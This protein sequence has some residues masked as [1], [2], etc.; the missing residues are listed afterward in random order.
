[1]RYYPE[2]MGHNFVSGL[3]T[4]K[5]KNLKA[6]SKK[7]Y[8]SSPVDVSSPA[9]Q[10]R[11]PLELFG[12]SVV[13]DHFWHLDTEVFCQ[14]RVVRVIPVITDMASNHYTR[15]ENGF[16]TPT[17]RRPLTATERACFLAWA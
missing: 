15:N 1:M 13:C 6:F 5:L 3:R 9:F 7:N 12:V 16:P 11:L 14:T 10:R 17:G 4:L 8:F 2:F